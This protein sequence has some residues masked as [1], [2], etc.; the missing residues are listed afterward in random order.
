MSGI[1][2]PSP[3]DKR[4]HIQAAR[5]WLDRAEKQFSDGETVI[6]SATL[7][8]A[9]AELKLLVEHAIASEPVH[10]HE[11]HSRKSGFRFLPISR[12]LLGAAGLAA[13]MLIGLAIGRV[14][15]GQTFTEPS[16]IPGTIQTASEQQSLIHPD[17]P[18]VSSIEDI[19]S[20]QTIE[21]EETLI[22]MAPPVETTPV[23][24][25]RP[26]RTAPAPEL[27]QPIAS[28]EYM[29]ETTEISTP[30]SVEPSPAEFISPAELA[31]KTILA[32][33]DRIQSEGAE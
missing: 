20:T 8:L 32:L 23:Y 14:T 26:S 21:A 5:N 7:M 31:L 10:T 16:F 28:P 1:P 2:N 18:A 25:P 13:C 3:R 33:T 12:T 11:H 17:E 15:A 27:E 6:A 4:L 30:I 22:A 24:R 29:I 19:E 9:Q